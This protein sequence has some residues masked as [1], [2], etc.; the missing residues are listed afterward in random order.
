MERQLPKNVRQIGNVCDEPKIYVEDYV[1]TFLGQLQEKAMERPVAA[2]LAGEITTCEDQVVVYISGAIQAEEVEVE[3]T[4]LKI[5]EE[6]REKIEKEQKEYFP[7]QKLIGWCLIETGHP[8]SLNRGAQELHR[9]MYDQENTIFI[10]KDAA[11]SDEMYFAY[12][13]NELMQI[14]GHYIYYEKNPQMQ[15]YMINTRRQNGVTPSEVVEDRAAKNFRSAVRQRMEIKEQSQS[16]K[17]LYATSALLVVV[18]L[19]I[20]VSTMNNFERMA[21]VQQSLEQLASDKGTSAKNEGDA[22]ADGTGVNG[23]N[24]QADEASANDEN[25]QAGVQSDGKNQNQS[26]DGKENDTVEASG[27][28][29]SSSDT[30]ISDDAKSQGTVPEVST[31]QEQLSQS[32]YYTVKKGDTLASIS[33]KTYGDSGHVEAICKMNGLSDGNLIFIGQKLLLP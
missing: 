33:K 7:D 22:Q 12:K 6:I 24:A 21:S 10:W 26:A 13:Y 9:E 19:A 29:K 4:N 18:V 1:D 5:P 30:Q 11:S 27:S 15:N 14:G 20:G 3:G 25:A 2:A 23:E 31:V 17:V 32:D 28:V 16:S 8:M